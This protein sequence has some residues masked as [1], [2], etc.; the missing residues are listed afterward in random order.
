MLAVTGEEEADNVLL[1]AKFLSKLNTYICLSL[2]GTGET[3]I[4]QITRWVDTVWAE[5]RSCVGGA[6]MLALV[7]EYEDHVRLFEALVA[8]QLADI[9]A[10]VTMVKGG[11]GKGAPNT[12]DCGGS[13]NAWT[14]KPRARPA[15]QYEESNSTLCFYHWHYQESASHCKLPCSW[16]GNTEGRPVI[17][18]ARTSSP[19]PHW[20]SSW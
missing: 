6:S 20:M 4:R 14:S 5:L 8:A 12:A 16:S 11:T 10:L 17:T 19:W 2:A 13:K 15:K 3:Y 1:H 7:N 18:M 9:M